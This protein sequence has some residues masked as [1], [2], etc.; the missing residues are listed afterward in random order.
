M[1]QRKPKRMHPN[2]LWECCDSFMQT[3]MEEDRCH[4]IKKWLKMRPWWKV[5]D[6]HFANRGSQFYI[7]GLKGKGC[8]RWSIS[9]INRRISKLCAFW[10]S[11]KGCGF[12]LRNRH[13][14]HNLLQWPSTKHILVYNICQ[15]ALLSHTVAFGGPW[16]ALMCSVSLQGTCYACFKYVMCYLVRQAPK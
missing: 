12:L 8:W 14:G 1:I 4:H 16:F 15:N 7:L 11:W 2:A 5:K 10:L 6:D 9:K 3:L 13:S